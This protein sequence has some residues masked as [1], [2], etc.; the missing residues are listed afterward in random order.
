MMQATG[1]P[2]GIGGVGFTEEAV[3]GLAEAASAQQRLLL[4]APVSVDQAD[5][6]NLY[7]NALSYW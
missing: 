7:R 4:V 5:L 2:N 1:V 6:R 3:D